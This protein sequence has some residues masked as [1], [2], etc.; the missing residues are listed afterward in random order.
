MFGKLSRKEIEEVL[1]GNIVGRI[2]CHADSRTYIVP[3][4]Y[5]YDGEY[6]FAHTQEGLKINIMRA[7][8]DVCFEVDVLENM[9]NWKSVITWGLFEE[10]TNEHERNLA[11]QKL[12]K[13]KF[14]AMASKTVQ[15]S[16]QW[17]FPPDEPDNVG[18]IFFR[19]RLYEKTG[20]Y[21]ISDIETLNCS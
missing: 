7:N 15:L 8:A 20:R 21:E 13:R 10:I 12:S 5:A 11:I 2:G 4:S 18:G 17:P 1:T 3:I 16:P 9:A 14:P 6:I 19:I